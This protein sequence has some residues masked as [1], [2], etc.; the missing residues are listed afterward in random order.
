MKVEQVENGGPMSTV[1]QSTLRLTTTGDTG[2][3]QAHNILQPYQV[4]NYIIKARQSSGVVATVVDS[5]DSTS[6]TDALSA[7]QGRL[8]GK[9][10]TN[11]EIV[12]GHWTDDKP[13]YRKVISGQVSTAN[14]WETI[15]TISNIDILIDVKG[16]VGGYLPVPVYVNSSY[17]VAVQK[18]NNEIQVRT[19]GYTNSDVVLAIEYTKTTD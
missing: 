2:G 16:T 18:Y 5:L 3:G 7:N 15:G 12:V 6:T 19:A 8:L 1:Q 14:T 17:N 13:V 9:Y 11:N 10:S 4:T